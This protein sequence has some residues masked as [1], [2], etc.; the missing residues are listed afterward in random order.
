MTNNIRSGSDVD[1]IVYKVTRLSVYQAMWSSCK[2][3]MTNNVHTVTMRKVYSVMLIS[4]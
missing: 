4:D 2:T 3:Y 1:Q